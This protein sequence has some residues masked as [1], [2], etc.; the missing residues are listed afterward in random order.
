MWIWCDQLFSNSKAGCWFAIVHLFFR[1]LLSD[2]SSCRLTLPSSYQRRIWWRK[3][4]GGTSACSSL[5]AGYITW[6]TRLSHMCCC[7]AGRSQWS[8]DSA[9]FSAETGFVRCWILH[10]VTY[11]RVRDHA[12]VLQMSPCIVGDSSHLSTLW[13]RSNCV[14]LCIYPGCWPFSLGRILW[15]LVST[16]LIGS[17]WFY[18]TQCTFG[19]AAPSPLA[20]IPV[21]L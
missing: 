3:R 5:R 8:K 16:M 19:L 9:F 10:T 20:R 14:I 7:F 1:L 6:C 4:S 11:L 21:L 18:G 13:A 2:M 17:V 15:R 12:L